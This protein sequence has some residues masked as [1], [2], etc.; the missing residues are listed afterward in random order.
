MRIVEAKM[1]QAIRAALGSSHADGRL[2]K[3]SNTEV[4]QTHHGITHTPGYYREVEIRLHGNL[5]AAVEP[6]LMRIRMDDCG[7]RTATTKSRLNALLRAFVPGEGI[8]Q[9]DWAWYTSEGAWQ[10]SNEWQMRLETGN[11]TLQQAERLAP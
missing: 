5:I 8:W 7:Y 3:C 2:L 10:G 4:T 6:D 1:I 9:Q 11:Y